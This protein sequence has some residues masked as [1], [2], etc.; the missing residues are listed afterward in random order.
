MVSIVSGLS[1]VG[2][3]L[4]A[5]SVAAMTTALGALP[6][7]FVDRLAARTHDT[8]LGFGAGVMLAASA[9]S[10][11]LPGLD[12]AQELGVGPWRAGVLVGLAILLGAALITVLDR[13]IPHEHFIKGAE[14]RSSQRLKRT[15]L[16]VFAIT[17]H[18][19]PEGLA[20]GVGFANDM[21]RGTA[22]ATGIAVQDIP[23]GLVVAVALI[24]AGYGRATA[25]LVGMASGLVEP[26]GAV[27]GAALVVALP[28]LLPF[29]LGFA[30]GAMLFV[31]SH[32]IIPESHRKGHERWATGGLM[33]GFV[34][35]M[36]LDTAL[37]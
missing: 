25:V 11:V 20:I 33:I 34:L 9:F 23:E 22:L 32:E 19:L 1:P 2:A 4:L 12:A 35:M 6:A 21:S 29:G 17:L 10:L 8:L 3:A 26:V 7:L 14:G 27:V 5:G 16:F 24:A 15:W 31:V 28:M 18:N 30:A 36:M 37:G 13:A